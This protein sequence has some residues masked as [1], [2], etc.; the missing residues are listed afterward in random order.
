[1]IEYKGLWT[2][3][4]GRLQ[5]PNTMRAQSV[6]KMDIYNANSSQTTPFENISSISISILRKFTLHA[7]SHFLVVNKFF[8]LKG[9]SA[10]FTNTIFPLHFESPI[11]TSITNLSV[12]C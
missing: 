1:M 4:L 12:S 10:P 3:V 5:R 7:H 2:F 11:F 6:M 9:F 8:Y